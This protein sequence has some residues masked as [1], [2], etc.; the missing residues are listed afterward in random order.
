MGLKTPSLHENDLQH[1]RHCEHSIIERKGLGRRQVREGNNKIERNAMRLYMAARLSSSS[2]TMAPF[3]VP[4]TGKH[5]PT[6]IS[7]TLRAVRP[8]LLFDSRP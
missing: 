5:M 2:G 1:C 7:N 6:H 4:M 3:M 8:K